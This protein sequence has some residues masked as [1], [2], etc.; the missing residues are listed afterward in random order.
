MDFISYF[1]FNRSISS[2][3]CQLLCNQLVLF[4]TTRAVI[5][6]V[7]LACCLNSTVC[8]HVVNYTPFVTNILCMIYNDFTV[9]IL[10]DITFVYL[11]IVLLC[12]FHLS[13][14]FLSK[15][16]FLIILR[17]NMKTIM[18]FFIKAILTE[19]LLC[20]EESCQCSVFF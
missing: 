17:K 8:I 18:L 14:L 7:L 6:S 13:K 20:C 11:C 10:I 1:L 4:E 5:Q 3:K 9:Y 16:I 19:D 15:I 2:T 12:L